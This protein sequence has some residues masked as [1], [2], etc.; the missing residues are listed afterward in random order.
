MARLQRQPSVFHMN[1]S[2][3]ASNRT[4]NAWSLVGILTLSLLTAAKSDTTDARYKSLGHR[5]ICTCDGEPATGM[6]QRGCKQVLL[7]CSHVDCEPSKSMRRELKDAL[8]KGDTDETILQS[9]AQK[10]GPDVVEQSNIAV[11]RITWVLA[12]A[13]LTSGLIALCGSGDR[14]PLSRK[15]STPNRQTPTSMAFATASS[16]RPP[17]TIGTDTPQRRASS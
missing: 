9:F 15:R 11:V 13:V 10:Y 2:R 6:G 8:A 3:K 4:R 12:L 16:G 5:L 17:T 7:E 14:P 1:P